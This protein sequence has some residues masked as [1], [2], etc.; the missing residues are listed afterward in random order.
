MRRHL[1]LAWGLSLVLAVAS[2]A[3]SSGKFQKVQIELVQT[4]SVTCENDSVRLEMQTRVKN[5]SDSTIRLG[6]VQSGHARFYAEDADGNL[7]LRPTKH[8]VCE[9]RG[10]PPFDIIT[11]RYES[12][13]IRSREMK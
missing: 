7:K 9:L 5:V 8:F 3:Q 11:A 4:G 6:R 13:T 10:E 12:Q 2:C 1:F